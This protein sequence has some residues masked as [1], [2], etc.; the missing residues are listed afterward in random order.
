MLFLLRKMGIVRR[1]E[2]MMSAYHF[3]GLVNQI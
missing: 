3:S 2:T 1:V